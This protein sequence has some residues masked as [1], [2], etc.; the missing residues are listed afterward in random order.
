MQINGSHVYFNYVMTAP[1][2]DFRT[3]LQ[4]LWRTL[5]LSHVTWVSRESPEADCA[6]VQFDSRCRDSNVS[7]T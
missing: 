6:V 7:Q 4:L 3:A 5:T 2:S 1:K